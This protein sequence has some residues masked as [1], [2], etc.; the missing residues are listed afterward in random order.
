MSPKAA[1]N[2]V[3]TELASPKG[4]NSVANKVS[5]GD[6]TIAHGQHARAFEGL[7]ARTAGPRHPFRPCCLERLHGLIVSDIQ[8]HPV[9]PAMPGEPCQSATKLSCVTVPDDLLSTLD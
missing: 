5:H 1:H 6:R 4:L 7:E 8:Q 2:Q 9:C 3:L